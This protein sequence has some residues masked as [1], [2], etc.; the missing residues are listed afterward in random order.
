MKMLREVVCGVRSDPKLRGPALRSGPPNR[1]DSDE[2]KCVS[3]LC[4]APGSGGGLYFKLPS[5]T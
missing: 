1:S 2:M 5:Q 4:P 3:A